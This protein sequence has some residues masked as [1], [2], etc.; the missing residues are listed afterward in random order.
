MNH[1]IEEE[2]LNGEGIRV[3]DIPSILVLE[4]NDSRKYLCRTRRHAFRRTFT[5]RSRTCFGWYW[6]CDDRVIS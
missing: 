2:A 5:S 6:Y 1:T 4:I 3:A